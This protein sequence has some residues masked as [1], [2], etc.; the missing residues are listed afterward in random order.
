[1]QKE[2]WQ[3]RWQQNQIGFHSEEINHHL[4]KVW[5][6]L[7]IAPG[8][9]VFVPFCGKSK[10]MLWL[11]A[12]GFEV[13][14]VELSQL[15]VQAFFA[16]NELPAATGR[17]G[18]FTVT[19]AENLRIYC[20]DFFDLTVD[21]LTGVAAVYDRASLVALPAGMR[22][23]YAAHM[24]QLLGPGTKTLLMTFD[25]SQHEMQGPPFSV[26]TAEV[27]ALYSSWCD[28]DLLYTRDILDREP[29]FRDKGVSWMQEQVYVLT[30]L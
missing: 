12:Q 20:G 6:A 22:A 14:G 30:G 2:F 11:Q 7:N 24:Q 23:A 15:A 26:Q 18:R 29:H 10:D 25:Y 9:R 27:L 17:Q 1:M 16:E 28:V 21:D 13:I 8:S 19:E 3:E 4:L 5:P